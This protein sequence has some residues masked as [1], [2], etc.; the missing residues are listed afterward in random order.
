MVADTK[1]I[2]FWTVLAFLMLGPFIAPVYAAYAFL[3]WLY[4]RG[5]FAAYIWLVPFAVLNTLHNWII[6]T[7]LFR[8]F[9]REFFTTQR[10]KRWKKSDDPSRRELADMLGGF[11]NSHDDGHY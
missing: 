9:P 1:L 3:Y 8:E 11:L 2:G 10:L 5:H 4:G 6:C 7:F